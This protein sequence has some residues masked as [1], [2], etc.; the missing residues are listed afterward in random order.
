VSVLI[1]ASQLVDWANTHEKDAQQQLPRLV[2]R[3]CVQTST[4]EI[5]FP[6]GDSTNLPGWDGVVNATSGNAWVPKGQ[7]LWELGCGKGVTAKANKD[8]KTRTENTTSILRRKTT[9]V[10]VTP[11]RWPG[12]SKWLAKVNGLKSWK[13][14]RAYDADDLEQWLEQEP[15]VS[16]QFAEELGLDGHGVVS[17]QQYWKSWCSQSNPQILPTAFLH[18]REE[19]ESRFIEA[20]KKGLGTGTENTISILADSVEEAVAFAALVVSKHDDVA[21][22]ATVVTEKEGWRFVAKNDK[23]RIAIAAR[24]DLAAKPTVGQGLLIIV[25]ISIGSPEHR[26]GR[27]SLAVI[28]LHR[29]EIYAFRDALKSIGVEEADAERM[30]LDAGRSWTVYRRLRSSNP[31]ICRPPW[32]D[33]ETDT[34]ILTTL[35]LMGSWVDTKEFDKQLVCKVSGIESYEHIEQALLRLHSHDDSPVLHIGGMWRAKSSI[36]LLRLFETRITKAQVDRFFD[37]AKEVLSASDPELDLEKDKRYLAG[38]YGKT[39]PFSGALRESICESLGRLAVHSSETNGLLLTQRV[40]SLIRATLKGATSTRWLSLASVLPEI[41]EAAPDEFL[42][43]VEASLASS[44]KSISSLFSESGSDMVGRNYHCHLLWGLERLAWNARW[45]PRVVIILDKLCSFHLAPNF[46]NSPINT[47]RGIF[48]SWLPQ[49]AATPEQR[50]KALDRLVADSSDVAFTLLLRLTSPHDGFATLAARPA[51]RDDNSGTQKGVTQRELWQTLRNYRERLLSLAKMSPTRVAAFFDNNASHQDYEPVHIQTL[52]SAWCESGA[53]DT[54]KEL[55]RASVRTRLHWI[56]NFDDG[57]TVSRRQWEAALELAYD[58]LKPK[59][60]VIRNA[61]L[62]KSNDVELPMKY[63][64]GDMENRERNNQA[65]RVA[66]V[67][68]M[69][70]SG[71][72]PAL[73]Q[74]ISNCKNPWIVGYTICKANLQKTRWKSWLVK[75]S[76]KLS[77]KDPFGHAVCGLLRSL[78]VDDAI[79]L[80]RAVINDKESGTWDANRKASLLL[81][82]RCEAEVWNEL[83]R[84]G[85]EVEAIYW[86]HAEPRSFGEHS[87]DQIRLVVRNLI[88]AGRPEVALGYCQDNLQVVDVEM[89]FE[90]LKKYLASAQIDPRRF[91]SWTLS[92]MVERLEESGSLDESELIVLEFSLFPLM[93]FDYAHSLKVLYRAISNDPSIFVQLVCLAYPE[94]EKDGDTERTEAERN[95]AMY[96]YMVLDE[97]KTVP[98]TEASSEVDRA[99]FAEYIRRAREL[100]EQA[101]RLTAC[102]SRLGHVLAYAHFSEGQI[103]PPA[104]VCELLERADAETLRNSF[105]TSVWNKRGVTTRG[106]TEGGEQERDVAKTFRSYSKNVQSDY[107]RVASLFESLAKSYDQASLRNDTDAALRSERF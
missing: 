59:D 91:A 105:S 6:A 73:E 50:L 29:T 76:D 18:E 42:D 2:R 4:T 84:H 55:I 104:Y 25:P 9:F 37:T 77:S 54:D 34:P 90:A 33:S 69:L 13:K 81:L 107:P 27:N 19:T 71:G 49:T 58:G 97:W 61:W 43:A 44:T 64:S 22:C 82:A 39:H 89:L 103:W 62:F 31:A 56:R 96:A 85:A 32:L 67:D 40:S 86:R 11:R 16:L 101:G 79:K 35:C 23:L 99:V 57:N 94:K 72:K 80:I 95:L 8:L 5:A 60:V 41:A 98:T 21:N 63:K 47:L 75:N 74:L 100:S 38:I 46:G 24:P 68:E 28:P 70:K 20:I 51:W 65:A 48:L 10:F 17:V 14:V 78:A 7:S 52:T 12:K 92:R 26:A 15:S 83:A 53:S 1:S 66:A 106:P 102:D 36:E 88:D 3:L 30:A 93:R 87:A 45:L